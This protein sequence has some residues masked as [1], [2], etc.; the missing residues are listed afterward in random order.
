MIPLGLDNIQLISD[1]VRRQTFEQA[2]QGGGGVDSE[3]ESRRRFKV[4]E[5]EFEALMRQLDNTVS[6]PSFHAIVLA[7]RA[8]VHDLDAQ[9]LKN[10]PSG[11][12]IFGWSSFVKC[13]F[14]T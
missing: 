13:H 9:T 1:D 4:G 12:P 7:S 3:G 5:M 11:H 10:N 2:N 6:K 8:S 14:Q